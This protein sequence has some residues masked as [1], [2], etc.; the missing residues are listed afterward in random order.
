MAPLKGKAKTGGSN[1][2]PSVR[3]LLFSAENTKSPE[4]KAVYEVGAALV[5]KLQILANAA[6]AK[7]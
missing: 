6:S 5:G 2:P 7:R 3:E 4:A 1:T